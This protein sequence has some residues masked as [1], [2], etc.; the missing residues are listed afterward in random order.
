MNTHI[1]LLTMIFW[2]NL[3]CI[4]V[5]LG[6]PAVWQSTRTQNCQQLL[7]STSSHEYRTK[8][9][10]VHFCPP[11]LK[12]KT[13]FQ[14]TFMILLALVSLNVVSKLKYLMLQ[15]SL[16]FSALLDVFCKQCSTNLV[17]QVFYLYYTC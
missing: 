5:I 16:T 14:T 1:I 7:L 3:S 10:R 8:V 9:C 11:K 15:I 17:T 6:F 13:V 12:S 2:V 4:G